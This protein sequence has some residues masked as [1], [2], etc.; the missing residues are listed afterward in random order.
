MDLAFPGTDF[1]LA[2]GTIATNLTA[3]DLGADTGRVPISGVVAVRANRGL[4]EIDQVDLQT[5]ATKLKATGRFSFEGD[6]NL[7][8]DLNSSDASELQAVLISSGL[9]TEVD[10]QMRSYGITLDGALNFQRKR[11][12]QTQL[13]RS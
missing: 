7:N 4:F 12:R 3:E 11:E 1:K 10:E 13:A 2:S 9:L 5:R 8:V 6:S